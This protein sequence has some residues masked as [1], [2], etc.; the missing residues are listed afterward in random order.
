[1]AWA[2]ACRTLRSSKGG[3]ELFSARITSPSVEPTATV[4]RGSASNWASVSGAGMP[5]K[6]SISSAS[7]AATAAGASG[8]KR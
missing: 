1:M 7:R 6:A 8:M 3:R 4:K 5:G 2:T